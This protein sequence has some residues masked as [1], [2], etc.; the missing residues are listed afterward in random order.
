ML[1]VEDG[2][3]HAVTA[4]AAAR[5]LVQDGV[6]ASIGSMSIPDCLVNGGVP[7]VFVKPQRVLTGL[8]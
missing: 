5:K 4:A 3:G 1:I 2:A 7:M 8:D 6:V